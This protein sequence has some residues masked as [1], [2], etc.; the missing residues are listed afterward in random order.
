MRVRCLQSI[1]LNTRLAL[2]ALLFAIPFSCL[3]IWLLF[4]GINANIQFARQERHGDDLQRPLETLLQALARFHL[5]AT[6]AAVGDDAVLRRGVDEAF[7]AVEAALAIH[8]DALQFNASGLAARQREQLAPNA[9]RERWK[10]LGVAPKVEA[11]AALIAD[12]RGMIGHMGDTSNLILDPDL[13]SYYV[14]DITLLALPQTHERIA[15]ILGRFVPGL[16]A[17]LPNA[18]NRR[19]LAVQGAFLRESDLERI[20]ASAKTALVED[21]NS[22]GLS[23]SLQSRL[24]DAVKSYRAATEAFL[25][26]IDRAADGETVTAESFLAAGQA[27]HEASFRLW[28]LAIEEL[29]VL[30]ERRIEIFAADRLRGLVGLIG[31]LALAG[32][33]SWLVAR[34][35][36]QELAAVSRSIASGAGEVSGAAREIIT[37]SQSLAVGANEQASAVEQTSASVEELAG[38]TRQNAEH[39][40]QAK[41]LSQQ[42]RAVAE[43]GASEIVA[44]N[45]AMDG[46][47]AASGNI[48]AI[49]Q[50]IDEISFQ[51]N[52]LALN[53]AVEAARAGE[54]GA[55]FAVVADEVRALAR[56][57]AEAA[58]ETSTKIAD[59]INKSRQGVEISAKVSVS[60]QE[61]VA[62]ARQVDELVA[63]IA[64]ASTEQTQGLQNI[65][66]AIGSIDGITQS[67]AASAEQSAAGAQTLHE[68]ALSLENAVSQ[69]ERLA[70]GN[71]SQRPEPSPS[72][73][74]DAPA[75]PVLSR[76]IAPKPSIPT[77][78]IS[79]QDRARSRDA[80]AVSSSRG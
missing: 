62:K 74:P 12:V 18:A 49:I 8:G 39:A 41:A 20:A 44:M 79:R 34:S 70:H 43:S 5:H 51:T 32:I 7:D 2:I 50:T 78:Q 11:S 42:T 31:T 59:A 37:S 10:A 46:I 68:E 48:A 76:S 3:T 26:Q 69:L 77:F 55:G 16:R 28:Q 35:I 53:A 73:V 66:K 22:S 1:R 29:D 40:A 57:S 64:S 45:A 15:N 14:M 27:A 72:T 9:V 6:G 56:R 71:A 58:K 30:L 47:K 52:V 24:P 75:A 38:M 33:A 61:I 67:T 80:L 17:G 21:R 23:P 4:K 13:D 36:R 65:A 63:S 25:E 54:A 19:A 60:L